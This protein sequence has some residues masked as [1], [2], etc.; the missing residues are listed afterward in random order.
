MDALSDFLANKRKGNGQEPTHIVYDSDSSIKGSY[1]IE[2]NDLNNLF[3]IIED[4]RNNGLNIC[5]LERLGDISPLVIDLDFKYK[6]NV[7]SR[8]YTGDFIKNLSIYLF[9][10]I[11]QLYD[12][13]SDSQSNI[14]V[15]E[16]PNISDCDKPQYP[17]KDGIHLMFPDI[18]AEKATYI[19]L[20][21][22]IVEDKVLL[23]K[24]SKIIV[25]LYHLMILKIYSI[26]IY[27]NL[28]IGSY[29]VLVNQ[30]ISYMN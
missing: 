26:L 20:M 24:Y 3:D 12:L 9:K 27:I 22:S 15:M 5:L 21:E 19:K 2:S 18:I 1:V 29:M 13:S 16:K 6:D 17:K 30:V 23:I 4:L 28:V 8:K 7:N 10:K 14:W 11:N 25:Y